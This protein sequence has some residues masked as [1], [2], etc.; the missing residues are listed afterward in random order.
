M[1]ANVMKHGNASGIRESD[2]KRARV[3][4]SACAKRPPPPSQINVGFVKVV[5]IRR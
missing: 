3:S 2:V 4:M 1:I 5:R